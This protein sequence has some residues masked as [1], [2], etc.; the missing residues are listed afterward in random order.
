MSTVNDERTDNVF[1]DPIGRF[2]EMAED[3]PPRH[4]L[5]ADDDRWIAT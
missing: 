5:V 1:V 3:A 2:A 4:R